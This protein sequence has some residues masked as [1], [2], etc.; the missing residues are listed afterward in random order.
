MN[1]ENQNNV[2][3]IGGNADSL[4]ILA[5][6]KSGSLKKDGFVD[7]SSTL[8]GSDEFC[9]GTPITNFLEQVTPC[10]IRFN[11]LS[12]DTE[13]SIHRSDKRPSVP[14]PLRDMLSQNSKSTIVNPREAGRTAF[15][16]LVNELNSVYWKS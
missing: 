2:H 9:G 15:A 10:R 12:R 5:A 3:A 16:K 4:K 1:V 11:L 7:E 8:E 14:S 6:P 13:V